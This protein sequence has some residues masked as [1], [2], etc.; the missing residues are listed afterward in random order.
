MDTYNSVSQS[1]SQALTKAYSTSFGIAIK[2]LPRA[3][4]RHIYNIYGLVRL[5]DEIVDTY[6]GADM[7]ELLN[8]LE[9]ETY[10]STTRQYSPN[11]IVNSFALS[12]K[13]FGIDKQIVEPF[14]ASMRMDVDKTG[15]YSKTQYQKYIHGSAEVVGLMCLRVFCNGDDKH[16]YELLPY[17]QSL[18]AAFQKVNFLRDIKQ[19]VSELHRS[20]FPGVNLSRIT[21]EQKDQIIADIKKDFKN[22]HIGLLKLPRKVRP[23]VMTAYNYYLALLNKIESSPVEKLLSER[24]RIPDH[25]KISLLVTTMVKENFRRV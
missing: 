8:D 17:A 4:R 5:A 14:F 3:M 13:K 10:I 11:L 2:L 23:A 24:I 19:D 7:L 18:G 1:A 16:Y 22:A 15:A 21:E 12:A 9:H 6:R 20:Y 25:S